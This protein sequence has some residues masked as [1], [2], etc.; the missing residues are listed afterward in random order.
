MNQYH[1]A[2]KVRT[3]VGVCLGLHESLLTNQHPKKL[4]TIALNNSR[5]VGVFPSRNL[6]HGF[7]SRNYHSKN[8]RSLNYSRQS[9]GTRPDPVN[10]AIGIT[11]AAIV[12]SS[13]SNYRHYENELENKRSNGE[14]QNA[15]YYDS[16]MTTQCDWTFGFFKRKSKSYSNT[17]RHN[18]LRRKSQKVV[19]DD[20]ANF[21]MMQALEV[22]D[23]FQKVRLARFLRELHDLAIEEAA[24]DGNTHLASNRNTAINR[25]K[26]KAGEISLRNV[27]LLNLSQ[28]EAAEHR[29]LMRDGRKF[30]RDSII[31]LADAATQVCLLDDT[32]VDL[33]KRKPEKT[34]VVGDL[35]GSIKCL[36]HVLDLVGQLEKNPNHYLVFCGDY[37]DRGSFSL[38]V[39]C[40][41]LFLKLT[42]PNQVI[43]LRGNHEDVYIASVYGFQE[44][45]REKYGTVDGDLI[46]DK[47]QQVF[48]SL[49]HCVRSNHA[50]MVHGGIP[51][52]NFE[53]SDLDKIDAETRMKV[54]SVI[55]PK[56]ENEKLLGRLIWSD[57][58]RVNG[59]RDNARGC[60]IEFGPDVAKDFLDRHE[61]AYIV[62]SHEPIEKGIDGLPCGDHKYVVT[63][64]STASYPNGT[65]TNLG[66]VVHIDESNGDMDTVQFE[67]EQERRQVSRK[68]QAHIKFL[69]DYLKTNRQ[70]LEEDFKKVE[71]DSLVTIDDWAKIMS[72]KLQIS[73]STWLSLQ[74]T[75]VAT[76]TPGGKYI[77]WVQFLNNYGPKLGTLKGDQK[78]LILQHEDELINLFK[79]LDVDGNGTID[80]EEVVTGIEM[81]NRTALADADETFANPGELFDMFDDDGNG[82]IDLDEFTKVIEESKVA[83]KLSDS[84]DTSKINALRKNQEMLLIA[85]RYLDRD[86]SGTIDRE[87]FRKGITLLNQRLPKEEQ[88]G[89]PDELFTTIDGDRSGEI[90]ITEFNLILQ[91]TVSS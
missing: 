66:A 29:S 56:N 46:W 13:A 45:I 49:P 91:Q 69:K 89:D 79:V 67:F 8:S 3:S 86:G 75:L 59:I 55:H 88:F 22:K 83:R 6:V 12:F 39:F 15:T 82:E 24:K 2:M 62:R 14:E 73:G 80:R 54:E 23:E 10:V 31:D 34:T 63:V 33:R 64:F 85:F 4:F 90:D 26:T 43:L 50:W 35:H 40:S 48:T 72:N 38:E 27:D 65:G 84:V 1:T 30:S 11:T 47:M 28:K 87:E 17:S 77:N 37:V 71:L 74:P 76:T 78:S 25:R 42:Y 60:G 52:A 20:S 5:R 32:Q 58:S 9:F 18:F 19:R 57:P 61:L 36:D 41:L 44:E 7:R 21:Q 81:L 68:S 70:G 16:T 51:S 53:L